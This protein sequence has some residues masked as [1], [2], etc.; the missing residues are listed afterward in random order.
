MSS[1]DCEFKCTAVP[2]PIDA[3]QVFSIFV[4]KAHI[5]YLFVQH[6]NIFATNNSGG[7]CLDIF[8]HARVKFRKFELIK[9]LCY[10]GQ[11]FLLYFYYCKFYDGISQLMV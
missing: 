1:E 2:S 4:F 7:E 3:V 5:F 8:N 10:S 6:K 11:K 9:C